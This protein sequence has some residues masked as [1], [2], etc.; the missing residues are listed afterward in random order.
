M[1]EPP[2]MNESPQITHT[3]T[4]PQGVIQKNLKTFVLL[5]VCAFIVIVAMISTNGTKPQKATQA[6]PPP[7]IILPDQHGPQQMHDLLGAPT[8][9]PPD[10]SHAVTQPP[11]PIEPQP[12]YGAAQPSQEEQNREKMR[13]QE[14]DMEFHARFAS[15]MY[16]MAGA[17]PQS[18]AEQP[19][20]TSA[21]MP[22]KNP[23]LLDSSQGGGDTG[24]A[25]KRAAEVDVNSAVGQP[26]VVRG[27][28]WIDT[29]LVNRLDGDA[30]GPV[31]VMVSYP[32]WSHDHQ[33]VLIPVGT[34]FDGESTKIG[35]SGFGQQRRIA[36]VFHRMIM[37]DGWGVDLDKAGALDQIGEMGLKDKVDNHYFQIFGTAL[38]LGVI[39]GA[40]QG[41]QG[42]NN[43]NSSGSQQ[44]TN[45]AASSVSQSATTILD[46]FIQIPPKIT[47]REGNR[48]HVFLRGDLL[49]PAM[50]NHT[51][52]QNF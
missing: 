9:E 24:P 52:P 22:T 6:P 12:G 42:G 15:N 5:G 16:K 35:G 28:S 2:S 8:P 49:L 47:I 10:G 20:P 18:A 21:D 13:Q 14:R 7:P 51:I 34:F 38:A 23:S 48:V 27:G 19:A 31:K 3:A 25:E 45:G 37:P 30:T 44:F 17:P 1:A 11:A 33:H 50:E 39:A 29:V 46:K 43:I 32:F 41:F 36:V 26:Y 40:A 4:E